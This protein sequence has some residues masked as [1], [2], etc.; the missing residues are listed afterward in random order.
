MAL[1]YTAVAGVQSTLG[2]QAS[3]MFMM[4][5]ASLPSN[6]SMPLSLPHR[7]PV[8]GHRATHARRGSLG[9]SNGGELHP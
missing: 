7:V 2:N 1:G 3:T 9:C 5:V 6:A 8:L 4:L